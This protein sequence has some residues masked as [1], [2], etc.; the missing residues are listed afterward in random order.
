MRLPRLRWRGTMYSDGREW[1]FLCDVSQ[2]FPIPRGYA[3][4]W[5][6][7]H[8]D[9]SV[10]APWGIAAL[11]GALRS[12]WH[13]LRWRLIMPPSARDRAWFQLRAE[14]SAKLQRAH[15]RRHYCNGYVD[16]R[17]DGWTN[18]HRWGYQDGYLA[19]RGIVESPPPEVPS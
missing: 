10:C 9:V 2:D 7:Y 19:A 5:R 3:V 6:D 15:C 4:A 16:G 8:A 18:G 17:H 13:F 1:P 12:G 11:L 14:V